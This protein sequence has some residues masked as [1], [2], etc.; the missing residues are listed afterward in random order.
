MSRGRGRQVI[1][2]GCLAR[3]KKVTYEKEKKVTKRRI[4]YIN[5]STSIHYENI[6]ESPKAM[7]WSLLQLMFP[8]TTAHFT[9]QPKPTLLPIG[10]SQ[11]LANA[12]VPALSFG[13][14]SLGCK[15][16]HEQSLGFVQRILVA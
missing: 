3:T 2:A 4:E 5:I 7:L 14:I 12:L 13:A 11:F 9:S 8:S 16:V 1:G 6:L 15:V 10:T